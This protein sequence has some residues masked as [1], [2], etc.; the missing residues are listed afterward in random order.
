MNNRSFKLASSLIVGEKF[1][2]RMYEPKQFFPAAAVD[3]TKSADGT[4]IVHVAYFNGLDIQM[5]SL[6]DST[7]EVS[8]I[9]ESPLVD[10]LISEVRDRISL[11]AGNYKA[12]I[13][14]NEQILAS[15]DT[16]FG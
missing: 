9:G 4:E 12:A 8:I 13:E 14:R 10:D 11:E 5:I 7:I 2:L 3:K 1:L 6:S 16:Y 15:L